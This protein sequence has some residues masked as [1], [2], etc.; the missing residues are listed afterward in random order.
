MCVDDRRSFVV[1]AVATS[2][3]YLRIYDD[4]SA[5]DQSSYLT[6]R[7]V[8]STNNYLWVGRVVGSCW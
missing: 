7:A 3:N 5:I 1:E 2:K 6:E 4:L 8:A